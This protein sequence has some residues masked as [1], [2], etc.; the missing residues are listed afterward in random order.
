ML[1]IEVDG[2]SHYT[3]QG[4]TH[5]KQRTDFIENLD[6]TTIRFTNDQAFNNL[7]GVLSKIQKTAE[8]L[9]LNKT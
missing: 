8:K 9:D 5:D 2:E 7:R 1:V 4:K 6:L 3:D